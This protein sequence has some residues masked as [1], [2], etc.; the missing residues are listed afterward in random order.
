MKLNKIL[1]GPNLPLWITQVSILLFV[2]GVALTVYSL[3]KR[4]MIVSPKILDSV[5]DERYRAMKNSALRGEKKYE[6]KAR[7]APIPISP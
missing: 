3:Q 6:F 1:H 7:K 5:A 4:K 2:I